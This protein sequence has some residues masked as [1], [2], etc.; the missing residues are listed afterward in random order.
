MSLDAAEFQLGTR[1]SS[2]VVAVQAPVEASDGDNSLS[3]TLMPAPGRPVVVS[4]TW[5]VMKGRFAIALVVRC[6]LID[7]ILSVDVVF[8]SLY[9]INN[10]TDQSLKSWMMVVDSRNPGCM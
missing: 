8:E 3:V 1:P 7:L 9:D 5:Q 4:R 10:W 2:L 6:D